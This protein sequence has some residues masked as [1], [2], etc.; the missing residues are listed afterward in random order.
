[1][2]KKVVAILNSMSLDLLLLS[3][4]P[5]NLQVAKLTSPLS[6]EATTDI[7]KNTST[8]IMATGENARI[9]ICILL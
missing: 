2:R 3:L 7:R 4:N 9:E 5:S 1:M 6:G 8:V